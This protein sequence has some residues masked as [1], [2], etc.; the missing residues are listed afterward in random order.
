[1]FGLTRGDL[2]FIVEDFLAEYFHFESVTLNKD[3]ITKLEKI[4]KDY[5]R[6]GEFIPYNS[7]RNN[8]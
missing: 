8:D 5:A 1:M 7:V 6:A 3:A 4:A 2:I